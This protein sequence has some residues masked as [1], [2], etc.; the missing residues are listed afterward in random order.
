MDPFVNMIKRSAS[1]PD[2]VSIKITIYRLAKNAKLIEHL[3]TAAENGKE[4][5]VLIELRA[6]FD[7]QNNIDWSER[8]EQAG[9]KIVYGLENYKVHSKVCLLYTSRCV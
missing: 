5:L 8:L 1:D 3:C 6:R 7:E 4:V 9:C 2:V